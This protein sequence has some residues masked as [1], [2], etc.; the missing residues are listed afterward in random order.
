MAHEPTHFEERDR[1]ESTR[2]GKGNAHGL[3]DVAAVQENPS[4]EVVGNQGASPEL[5]LQILLLM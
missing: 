4:T 5:L 3:A 1:H 2:P